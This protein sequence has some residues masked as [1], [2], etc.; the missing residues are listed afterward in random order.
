[1]R[2]AY[3][4]TELLGDGIG[5]ELSRAI[6]R[7]AEALPIRLEFLAVDFRLE[8]RR[9]NGSAVYEKRRSR[10]SSPKSPT[11]S[12]CSTRSLVRSS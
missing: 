3:S 7:L 6:H 9:A 8:N 11:P 4:V 5:S 1:M 2:P 10:V 12:S